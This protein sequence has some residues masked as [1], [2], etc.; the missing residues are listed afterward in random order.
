M[1]RMWRQKD[2]S[3]VYLCERVGAKM[4]THLSRA[5]P[6]VWLLVSLE[7]TLRSFLVLRGGEEGGV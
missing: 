2:K 3:G 6:W 1:M 7:K 4:K 5:E